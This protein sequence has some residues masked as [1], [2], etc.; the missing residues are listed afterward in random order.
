M[1]IPDRE[2]RNGN[3]TRVPADLSRDSSNSLDIMLLTHVEMSKVCAKMRNAS[4]CYLPS[5]CTHRSSRDTKPEM[6]GKV[7]LEGVLH[8]LAGRRNQSR[9]TLHQWQFKTNVEKGGR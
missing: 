6:R 3:E 5:L 8:P 1:E 9:G 4:S 7:Q 2:S